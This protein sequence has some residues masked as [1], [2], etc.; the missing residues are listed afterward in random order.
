MKREDT[1]EKIT[2]SSTITLPEV[3]SE[4]DEMREAYNSLDRKSF[5]L[6]SA[7]QKKILVDDI[8]AKFNLT[9]PR[10]G[11]KN[12]KVALRKRMVDEDEDEDEDEEDDIL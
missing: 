6:L 3:K 7:A 1:L 11:S 8:I 9:V 2:A 5:N 12:V 10:R 4:L